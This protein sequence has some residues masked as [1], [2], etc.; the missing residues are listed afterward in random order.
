MIDDHRYETAIRKYIAEHA[1]LDLQRKYLGFSKTGMCPRRVYQEMTQG[2]QPDEIMFNMCYIGYQFEAME[3]E[4]L[5]GIGFLKPGGGV[6]IVSDFSPMFI[7]HSD[8]ETANGDLLEIKSVT[9]DKFETIKSEHRVLPDHFRQV[10]MYMHYGNYNRCW[11]DYVCRQTFQHLIVPV[12][13]VPAVAEKGIQ[14]AKEVLKAVEEQQ[15]PACK[16]GR[17]K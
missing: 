13:Y 6:E 2:I 8:G 4:I 3:K 17:C 11:F 9:V 1:H 10:Q 7:G 16:C 14:W 5:E 15:E 12:P